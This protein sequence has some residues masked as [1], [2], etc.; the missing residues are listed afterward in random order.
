[1]NAMRTA[2]CNCG[3]LTTNCEGAP[4]RISVCHCL[5][6]KRRT[7]SAF[8][9]NATFPAAAVEVNGAYKTFRC[10]SETGRWATHHFC[11][12]CG[13]TL[14]YEIEER[15]GM[16][17]V[18]AGA[19]ADP[20]FPEPEIEVFGDRR[21]PWCALHTRRSSKDEPAGRQSE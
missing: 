14:F 1:M 10:A 13:S 7:G 11:P 9:Y 18:P 19:F 6:C 2:R 21:N 8:S 20:N 5:D 16:I 17:T 3:S 4:A 15:P 12:A